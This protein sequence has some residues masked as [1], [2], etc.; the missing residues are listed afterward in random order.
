L[1]SDLEECVTGDARDD[2]PDCHRN[3]SLRKGNS[4]RV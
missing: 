1:L 2:E 4:R 3:C